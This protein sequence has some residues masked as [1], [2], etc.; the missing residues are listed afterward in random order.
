MNLEV[1]RVESYSETLEMLAATMAHEVKNPLALIQANIDY[2]ELCDDERKHTKNYS[3]M[4][5]EL[6]KAN[7]MLSGF[8]ALIHDVYKFDENIAIYD[9][10]MHVAESYGRS[11]HKNISIQVSCQDQNLYFKGNFQLFTICVSNV[12][13]NAAE[14][15]ADAGGRIRITVTDD[16]GVINIETADNG[17]G[18]SEAVL[19][20]IRK[21]RPYTSKPNGSGSGINICRSII[22]QHGG[23]YDIKNGQHGGCVVTIRIPKI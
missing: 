8:I 1:K 19:D 7:G 16:D 2:L 17:A 10:V 14:A 3:V 13:K 11:L 4:R 21:G 15:I 5:E 6:N 20:S 18:L 12:I 9:V 23:S 22:R